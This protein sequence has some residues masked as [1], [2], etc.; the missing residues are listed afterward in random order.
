MIQPEHLKAA[1]AAAGVSQSELARRTGLSSSMIGKLARGEARQSAHI[2]ELS[3]ALGVSPEYLVGETENPGRQD[4]AMPNA[5]IIAEEL[6]MVPVRHVDLAIGMGATFLDQAI[7]ET[8]R[9]MPRE[10]LDLYTRSPADKLIVAQGAGDSM[11]PTIHHNDLVL[12]DTTQNIPQMSDQ[13]FAVSYCGLGCVKRLRPT[14]DG[15]WLLFSDNP[16][17]TPITAYDGEL[18]VLGRV[19]AFFRK[20]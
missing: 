8:Q 20:M 17:I 3:R 9:F 5:R 18:H 19:V 16:T 11:F 14:N 13:V 10:W 2:F 12:I 15:G 7:S 4:I 1:M 6:G